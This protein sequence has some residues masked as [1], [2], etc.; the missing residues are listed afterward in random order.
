M[1]IDWQQLL[2]QFLGGLG[3]FLFS[4]QYMGEGFQ[5]MAGTRLRDWL[6][7]YTSTPIRGVLV[8]MLI[9][10][11]IQSSSGT[12]VLTVGLVSA[13]LMTLRQA[14]PVIM[15]ANIGT[16]ITAFIIGFQFEE[17]SYPFLAL[18]AF[19]LFF[20]KKRKFDNI[21]RILFGFGGLFAGLQL[22]SSS[23]MP[24]R[25]AEA[26]ND[27][28]LSMAQQPLLGVIAGMALTLIMQSS[29][30][31]IAILQSMYA[32]GLVELYAAVPIVFGDNIGTTITAILASLGATVY[33]KRAA[34]VHLLFNVFG[35]VMFLLILPLFLQ[36]ITSISAL[37]SLG[38]EMQIAVAHGTFNIVN[39]I[40]QLPFIGVLLWTVKKLLPASKDAIP[41][42][43]LELDDTFIT[44]A[45]SIAIGQAKEEVLRMGSYTQRGLEE[46]RAFFFTNDE[47]H[48]I[49]VR[50]YE[51]AIN[52]VDEQTTAYLMRIS[53]HTLTDVD[54]RRYHVVLDQMKDFE[55][56]AGHFKSLLELIHYKE[57][58]NIVLPEEAM[59]DIKTMFTLTIENIQM[60][61]EIVNTNDR[62]L[63]EKLFKQERKID[64]WEN[65]I[66]HR[67][68]GGQNHD[69]ITRTGSV[70]LTDIASHLERI[71]DRT[72]SIANAMLD[73]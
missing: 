33:A 70:L 21:G 4:I 1:E 50:Q 52:R 54:I 2:F 71:S 23:L 64:E 41:E 28:M 39:T 36:Y 16:T 27:I 56:I 73:L 19:L 22:M 37:L 55:R 68:I 17:Y 65:R 18:G 3:L 5:K 44:Q 66:R 7:R 34:L 42:E 11:L 48:E 46:T 12:T 26:F 60:A 8:G 51:E 6:D 25:N 53:K 30:A 14:I 67:Y 49:A 59:N 43:S 47:R 63:A 40:I 62:Q 9:T 61:I 58:V 15:G 20:F 24:L 38:P 13:R 57:Q 29:S 35:T 31:T 32:S 45:P 69:A 10:M 72:A